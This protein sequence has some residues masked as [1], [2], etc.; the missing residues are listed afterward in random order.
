MSTV[1]KVIISSLGLGC[2]VDEGDDEKGARAECD[3]FA[4]EI[5]F[6]DL[7]TMQFLIFPSLFLLIKYIIHPSNRSW[8]ECIINVSAYIDPMASL[9]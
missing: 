1:Q 8:P 7:K 3:L 4:T 9:L 2:F 6:E 5:F